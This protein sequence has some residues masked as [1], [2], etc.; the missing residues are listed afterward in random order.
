MT[1]PLRLPP[2]FHQRAY[3]GQGTGNEDTVGEYIDAVQMVFHECVRVTKPT[4]S[5]VFNMGDKYEFGSLELVPY[6]FAA[7]M[8]EMEGVRLANQP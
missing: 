6:R 1:L 3:A 4:G 8:L 2:Y 5:I 7:H